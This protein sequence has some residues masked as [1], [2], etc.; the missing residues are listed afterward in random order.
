[1]S[2]LSYNLCCQFVLK[3][4]VGALDSVCHVSICLIVSVASNLS[5]SL[6]PI[7]LIV[8][9]NFVLKLKNNQTIRGGICL[10]V[11]KE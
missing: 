9:V 6:C 7:C 3:K 10:I 2:S 11:K 5:Y 1:V 8:C 4:W